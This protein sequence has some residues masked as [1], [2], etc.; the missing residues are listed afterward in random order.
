MKIAHIISTLNIGG[1]ENFVVQLANQQA[2]DH[3][4]S[5]VVTQTTN[6]DKNY[7]AHVGDKIKLY[8]LDWNK[9][10]SPK[11]LSDLYKL[12]KKINPKQLYV[13]LH[14]P[15]YYVYGISFFITKINY[16]HTIHSSF[17]NWH[18]ILSYL[19]KLRFI[20]NRMLHVCVAKSIYNQ[21]LLHYPKLKST[22]ICNGMKHYTPKR[23]ARQI[24]EFWNSFSIKPT[25]GKRFLA[26]GNINRHKNFRL[27]ALCFTD[28]FEAHPN[29]MCVHIGYAV[30][31]TLSAELQKISAP[32]LFLAGSHTNAADFL[33]AA[34]AL[35]I[36]SVQE[37]MPIVALE[38]LSMGIPIISTPAGGLIDVIVDGHNGFLIDDF[39]IKSL[40]QA[41]KK[42]IGISDAAKLKLS[43]NA[44]SD[45]EKYYE[46]GRVNKL[47]QNTYV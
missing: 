1:A 37:G 27:L 39:K 15:L 47:Y 46:I 6:K 14:N 20:N 13:H 30:D 17:A 33:S 31:K 29:A 4:V 9:K 25:K 5:I 45:F 21:L 42:F 40:S 18:T 3:E 16:I 23:E 24:E 26:I 8:A 7:Y 12:I 38:A 10:Y 41:I 43:Q 2:I 34:D 19:N 22:W 44:R 11:Q 32:N 36:S 35:I 28:I